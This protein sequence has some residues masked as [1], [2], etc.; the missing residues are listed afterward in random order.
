M[1]KPKHYF[2]LSRLL[3]RLIRLVKRTLE[4]N[5]NNKIY[6]IIFIHKGII[7]MS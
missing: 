6:I 7:T 1:I 5:T 3:G 2:K 4:Q